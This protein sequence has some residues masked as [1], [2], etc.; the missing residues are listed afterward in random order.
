[1]VVG[2]REIVKARGRKV[3]GLLFLVEDRK[4]ILEKLLPRSFLS[5]SKCLLEKQCTADDL[6]MHHVLATT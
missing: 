1:M 2:N 5:N 4:L 3:M 6:Q